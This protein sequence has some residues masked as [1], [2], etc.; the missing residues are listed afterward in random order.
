MNC[1]LIRIFGSTDSQEK[2]CLTSNRNFLIVKTRNGVMATS[3]NI[4]GVET[5][6]I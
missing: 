6:F 2:P 1:T 4:I 3:I 5:R